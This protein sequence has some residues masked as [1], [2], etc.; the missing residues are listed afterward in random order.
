MNWVNIRYFVIFLLRFWL[1]VWNYL[2]DG[3]QLLNQSIWYIYGVFPTVVLPF[4]EKT[5]ELGNKDNLSNL[6]LAFVVSSDE[7]ANRVA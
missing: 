7:R 2:W 1:I 3:S 4:F 5:L 6:I